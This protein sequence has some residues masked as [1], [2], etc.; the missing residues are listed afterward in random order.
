MP[1]PNRTPS[2]P[3]R[4]REGKG[5]DR[6]RRI[7][8]SAMPKTCRCSTK[9]SASK[10]PRAKSSP[11]WARPAA[12]RARCQTAAGLLPARGRQHQ[13]RRQ[14]HPPSLRQRAAPLLR[15]GAAG[16]RAVLRHDL[17]QPADGQSPCQLRRGRAR[18]QDGRDPQTSSKHCRKATRPKSASAASA[19]PAG[20][21]S[22]SPSRAR[23]SSDPK[24]LIFD[25]ATSNLDSATAEHFAA[26][27]NQL[28]GKV[29]MLFITHAMPKNLLV[30][31]VVRIGRSLIAVGA[32]LEEPGGDA[33]TAGLP[34]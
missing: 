30:D 9:T 20:R 2:S 14:R 23:C 12:A 16:N 6:D 15:R 13:D 31:E 18:L 8:A 4:L 21:S 5:R 1:R 29:T 33:K 17:R 24:I 3:A 26:T 22:A 28:K 11:S 25:E 27:I 19:S 34:A 32:G 10:C 7:S